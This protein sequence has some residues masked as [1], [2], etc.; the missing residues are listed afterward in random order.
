[1]MPRWT[2]TILFAW[3]LGGCDEMQGEPGDYDAGADAYVE[4]LRLNHLQLRGTVNSAHDWNEEIPL[5]EELME[6]GAYRHLPFEE[7]AGVQGI[8][9]FDLDLYGDQVGAFG[10]QVISDAHWPLDGSICLWP[11][12]ADLTG[13]G[14]GRSPRSDGRARSRRLADARRGPGSGDGRAQ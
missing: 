12:A 14:S 5:P 9:Q 13:R 2:A 11:R 10:M 6:R 8:R 7:Q 3:A 4:P 1:M